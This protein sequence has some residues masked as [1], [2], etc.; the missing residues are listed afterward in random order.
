MKRIAAFILFALF[1]G[2]GCILQKEETKIPDYFIAIHAEPYHNLPNGT[3]VLE[4]EYSTLKRMIAKAD[5]Y[6]IKLTLMFS[7][8]WAEYIATSPERMADL[9]NWKN[10]GHE[11]ATHHHSIYH[12]NWD[13][14]T[15]YSEGEALAERMKRTP[16]AEE[17]LGTLD[18]FISK[19]KLI[20]EN[21]R[22]GCVNDES[23]KLEMPDA[24]IY[25]TC[26][27]FANHGEAG[28]RANDNNDAEKGINEFITVGNANGILRKWLTHFQAN[29]ERNE[30]KAEE[31][32]DSMDSG[33]YG[34]VF[35]AAEREEEYF[36][37]WLEFLHSKDPGGEN[38]VTV[39]EI[40]EQK[41]IPEKNISD[42][43]ANAEYIGEINRTLLPPNGTQN[44][45]PGTGK[46]G[47]GICDQFEEG[48]PSLCPQDCSNGTQNQ[49]GNQLCGDGVCDD[50]EKANPNICP[51]D[52]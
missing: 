49:T 32:F 2:N 8:Q 31:A 41:L 36:Y 19:M 17:Y 9:E 1:L 4:T 6:H 43:L 25:D 10:A 38:S 3:K 35:H 21:I 42:E 7:P 5:E 14:Y 30:P 37:A 47:D 27:G 34:S 28:T 16:R 29:N 20:N 13:G 24:I 51:Q 26:S 48:N 18:D 12:G 11:I 44:G 23:D 22:S 33:V 50:I 15:D 40:I 46:C 52:C 45:K 39:S